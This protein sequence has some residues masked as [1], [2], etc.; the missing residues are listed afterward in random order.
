MAPGAERVVLNTEPSFTETSQR[1]AQLLNDYSKGAAQD[2]HKRVAA[3]LGMV[4]NE[5]GLRCP[6]CSA[7]AGN[8]I[9]TILQH[10]GRARRLS[11][12]KK[13]D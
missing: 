5:P 13:K 12:L 9:K 11:N 4:D 8:M 1:F 3:L 2:K 7:F 10:H 6:K